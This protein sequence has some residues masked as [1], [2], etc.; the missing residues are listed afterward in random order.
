MRFS[1][2]KLVNF[3]LLN[4]RNITIIQTGLLISIFLLLVSSCTLI[5]QSQIKKEISSNIMQY[6]V[7]R[8]NGRISFINEQ[9]NWYAKFNWMQQK[10]DFEIRFT[11]PLGETELQI[12]QIDKHILLKTPSGETSSDD[13]EQLL[14]QETGWKFPV[15]SL[16]Y[17]SQGYPDPNIAA[18]LK[19]NEQ[20]QISDIFQ[21]GW[22]IQYPKRMEVE[23]TSG[24]IAVLP[25]KIIAT[26]QNVKIKLIIT[27]WHLGES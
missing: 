22:H 23:Q 16:R 15:T 10:E 1:N 27:S 17:W 24:L 19:Y 20:Q 9:E 5:P 21:A 12:S 3:A 2:Y 4:K 11:G 14:F 7:W 25:K 6:D 8:I 13:L 18:Q 26:E